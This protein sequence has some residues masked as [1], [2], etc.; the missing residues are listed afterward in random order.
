MAARVPNCLEI[1]KNVTGCTIEITF[2]RK[3][4]EQVCLSVETYITQLNNCT[5][6]Y[7]SSPSLL[8]WA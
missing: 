2:D 3:K 4:Y 5:S 8:I 7:T 1:Q 6:S